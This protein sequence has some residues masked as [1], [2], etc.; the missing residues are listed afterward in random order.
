MSLWGDEKPTKRT[1]GIRDRQIVWVKANK[2]CENCGR[3]LD[4]H[5][6]Q[7]GHKTAFS[8]GGST[9]MKNSVCLCY[10][11]NKLQGTDSWVTFQKKQGKSV[12]ADPVKIRLKKLTITQLKYLAKEKDIKLKGKTE[13]SFFSSSTIP[14][15]KVQYV[16]ALSKKIKEKEI[17]DILKNK[18]TTQ[19]RT[20]KKTKKTGLFTF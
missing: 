16:N 12:E 6:M 14:P 18:P 2:K 19:K 13:E 8:K 11:C 4:F 15:S 10:A 3:P 17:D 20:R 1:L 7:I 9:T 5:E